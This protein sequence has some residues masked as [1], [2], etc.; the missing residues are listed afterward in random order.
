LLLPGERSRG[1]GRADFDSFSR[2]SQRVRDFFGE[3]N[4]MRN[5]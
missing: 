1:T 3:E 5:K 2:Q 4:L